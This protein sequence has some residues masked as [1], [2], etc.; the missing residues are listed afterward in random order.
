MN[1]Y[2]LLVLLCVLLFVG[3]S[4]LI[5]RVRGRISATLRRHDSSEKHAA[6]R[7]AH[8]ARIATPDWEFYERHLQRPVPTALRQL[9]ADHELL[10]T[11]G[12]WYD[13]SHYISAFEPLDEVAVVDTANLFGFD[14]VPFANSNGDIIYLRPGRKEPDAVYI[15]YHDG[16]ETEQLAPDVST[17]LERARASRQN[18]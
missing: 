1:Q 7:S 8:E 5:L 3:V 11:S 12:I 2:L 16:G 18:G 15:T 10:C 4:V 6:E 17:F 9:Y 13:E 14:V